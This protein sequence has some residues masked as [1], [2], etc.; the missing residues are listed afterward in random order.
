MSE[1]DQTGSVNN[2]Y[3][4]LN[5]QAVAWIDIG[6]G[7]PTAYRYYLHD[8]LG[9][10]RVMTTST[11]SVCYDADFFPW[12]GEQHLFTNTCS[13]S[14]KFTGK[15]RDPDTNS[16]DYF[17]ARWYQGAM[18]RF[19]SPDPLAGSLSNPQSLNRY[20]YSLNNPLKFVDPT[21][22]IVIWS[23]SKKDK[24]GK[25]KAQRAFEKRLQEL[26]NSKS[27]KDR[28]NGAALQQTYDRLDASKA[29]FEVKDNGGPGD[30]GGDISYQGNDHFTIS[31][32]G[33][34]RYGLTDDQRIAHEFEHGRQVLD[35]E[36][37]F[38]FNSLNGN[39]DPFALDA[40]DEA[41][42]Y[43]AGF[44]MEGATPGQGVLING[45]STALLGGISG[46]ATYLRGHMGD[47][48]RL[49][50]LPLDVP[51]PPP[52]GVYEVPK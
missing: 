37:S 33:S 29:T 38:K 51:N 18:A 4:Y 48:G 44:A 36:L 46:E 30:N 43:A 45:A 5:R 25:T 2:N 14:Y 1:T 41:K 39:W 26:L 52:P 11:G 16:T 50:P 9:T 49:T 31:L 40:T 15:E 28:S 42:G 3:I 13:Q 27:A 17:E 35:G 21:G 19:Y 10:T 7:V 12:G 20:A 47:Y 6:H 22:M 23:D 32:H 24:D 34:D 8:H